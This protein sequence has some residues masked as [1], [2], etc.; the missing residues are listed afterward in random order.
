M[1]FFIQISRSLPNEDSISPVSTHHCSARS[2]Q[3]AP[4]KCLR[5]VDSL[6]C[7]MCWIAT[8]EMEVFI[9][10]FRCRCIYFLSSSWFPINRVR[11]IVRLLCVIL[12]AELNLPVRDEHNPTNAV[13]LNHE[14]FSRLNCFYFSF[15]VDHSKFPFSFLTR[16]FAWCCHHK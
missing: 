16:A 7:Y 4:F 11:R 15:H 10:L 6:M 2:F 8:T 5:W 13:P 12:T 3:M 1:A 14:C 9:F